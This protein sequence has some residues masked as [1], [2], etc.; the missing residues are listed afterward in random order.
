VKGTKQGSILSPALFALYV[1]ELL[2]E[3]KRLG[4]GCK[5]AYVFM[6][7]V[8]FCDDILLLAPSRSG[9]QVVVDTKFNLVFSTDPNPE[10]SKT[11]CIFVCVRSR[12]LRKPA[13][14]LLDGKV[15]PW[16]ESAAHRGNVNHESMDKD[17]KLKR[18][19]FIRESTELRD[20]DL[21]API[22]LFCLSE[23][24]I[25]TI[26]CNLCFLHHGKH[27]CHTCNSPSNAGAT[28]GDHNSAPRLY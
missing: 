14:L 25:F 20:T 8:G 18:P 17:A 9:M 15:L 10:E 5:V 24:I 22:Y 16:V 11:K 6:G 28:R 27:L 2:V 23:G 7:A 3:L 1:D 13:P 12:N 21:P 26:I 19:S 4:I